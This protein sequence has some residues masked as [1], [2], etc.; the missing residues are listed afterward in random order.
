MARPLSVIASVSWFG[1]SW[2]DQAF[3]SWAGLRGA[4]PVV[5]ATVPLTT[6]TPDTEWIFDLVFVLVVVFTIVQAPT[7][8]WMARRLG[9]TEQVHAVDVEALD[10]DDEASAA[11]VS[12]NLA[13][14][15][16]ARAQL[17]PTFQR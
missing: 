4:V 11:V 1:M 13:F 6:G 15:T 8:P 2:R 7:L 17:V 14:H 5:L 3:L 10:V 12:F 16:L 9:L